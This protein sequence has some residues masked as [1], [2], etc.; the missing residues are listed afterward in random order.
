MLNQPQLQR[1]VA[2]DA[3]LGSDIRTRRTLTHRDRICAFAQRQRQRINQYGFSCTGFTCKH[4]KTW[5]E[6]ENET[7]YDDKIT[8]GQT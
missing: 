6:I 1:L 7:L 2:V 3:K 4:G 5:I 8:N